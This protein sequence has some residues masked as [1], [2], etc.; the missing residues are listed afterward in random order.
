M[1]FRSIDVLNTNHFEDII[2][3]SNGESL[4]LEITG[5]KGDITT[6]M[7][8]ELNEEKQLVC[9]MWLRD[10]AAGIGTI[11]FITEDKTKFGALGHPVNDCDIDKTYD[12]RAGT[13]SQAEIKSIKTGERNRPVS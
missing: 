12:L 8:P 5:K 2:K 9:G 1:L 13:V 10:S 11:T 7:K 4:S 6:V 3:S